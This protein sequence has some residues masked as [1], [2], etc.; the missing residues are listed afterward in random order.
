[1][2]ALLLLLL[3]PAAVRCWTPLEAS[4]NGGVKEILTQP[5]AGLKPNILFLLI[6][7][8]VHASATSDT[9]CIYPSGCSRH[10]RFVSAYRVVHV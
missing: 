10:A 9:R 8:R 2:S 6:D 3:F 5:A 4:H 1:M 7:V